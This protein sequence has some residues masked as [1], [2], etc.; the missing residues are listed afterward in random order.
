MR[1]F[2][3]GVLAIVFMVYTVCVSTATHLPST[4]NTRSTLTLSVRSLRTIEKTD[5]I[6]EER[7]VAGTVSSLVKSS[8]SKV[9][10]SAA[11]KAYLA[12]N[13]DGIYVLNKL[14]LGNDVL[15]VLESPKL[16]KLSKYISAYNL[17]HPD[18]QISLVGV[19]ST[20]YG[21][22]AVAK[23]LVTAKGRTNTAEL[24]A[25]LQRQQL[26][27]WLDNQKSIEYVMGK[28][29]IG[30]DWTLTMS[31]R[32][33]DALDEYI[34]LFNVRYPLAKTD[35]TTE[36]AKRFGGEAKFARL[37]AIALQRPQSRRMYANAEKIQNA[38][39]KQWK[40]RGLDPMSVLV[41][42]FK[43][44]EKDV[45]SAGSALKNVVERYK[46]EVYR[47]PVEGIFVTPRRS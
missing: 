30:D 39:F 45:A 42:V 11:L 14:K 25:S 24:A 4:S 18:E 10:E 17:K 40:D 7:G 22:D 9:I 33:L 12:A 44:D 15:E 35:I 3:T 13:K 38:L 19:L 34:R 5:R 27:G 2:Y 26:N 8:A 36:L 6:D 31:S 21:D 20:R 23:A 1:F 29:K 46:R 32:S 43:V 16:S 37:V 28:L 41:Q 47:G